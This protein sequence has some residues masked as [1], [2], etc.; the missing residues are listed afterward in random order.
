M[1]ET[2]QPTRTARQWPSWVATVA[3]DAEDNAIL[4]SGAA[5][6]IQITDTSSATPAT[7]GLCIRPEQ[8]LTEHGATEPVLVTM[9]PD[10]PMTV[11]DFT[12]ADARRVAAALIEAA[13]Q[14]ERTDQRTV[15]STTGTAPITFTPTE[16]G[17]VRIDLDD[18]SSQVY[19]VAD[20]LAALGGAR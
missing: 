10:A 5:R 3:R 2:T 18:G 11:R 8:L 6:T 7:I 17:V 20:L 4:C 19:R 16:P 12:P 15:T 14:V 9:T 1:P 13:D